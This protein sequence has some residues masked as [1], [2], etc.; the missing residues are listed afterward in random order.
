M[1]TGHGGSP[2]IAAPSAGIEGGLRAIDDRENGVGVPRENRV[3]KKLAEGGIATVVGGYI[4]ADIIEVFGQFPFDGIWIEAEHGP[5]D[6]RDI[7]NLT[8]ACDLWGKTSVVRVGLNL[9]NVIYR[10]LDLGAQAIV[11]PHVNTADEARA[12]VRAA[13]YHPLGMRG[14]YGGRQSLGVPD[15]QPKA[16]EQTMTIVLVEDIAAV[17]NLPEMLEVDGIDVFFVAPG[18]LAQTM[19]HLGNISHP[20]VVA[21]IRDAIGQIVGA[22]RVAGAMSGDE[23]VEYYIDLGARFLFNSWDAWLADGSRTFLDRVASA[24]KD[25]P[26]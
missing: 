19:G 13:K 20:D 7:P 9:E 25:R 5:V 2:I 6:Y 23:I 24:V 21:T 1:L 8:R 26:S 10:T 22:G 3:K 18:D 17:R 15:Y 12:V 14:S 11:V 16:N 4:T